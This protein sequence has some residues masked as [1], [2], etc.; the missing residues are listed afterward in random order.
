MLSST[1]LR[2]FAEVA[3]QGSFRAAAEQLH[4]AVSAISRQISLLEEELGSPLFERGRGRRVLHLTAAGEHLLRYV[5]DLESDTRRMRSDI[6]A[7]KGMHKGQIR[8]GIP[9]SFIHHLVPELLARFNQAYPAITYR[10]EVANTPRLLELVAEGELDVVLAYNP[11]ELIDVKHVH[12]IRLPRQVLVPLGHPLAEREWVRLSDCAQYGM[13]LPGLSLTA[14]GI[15]DEMFAKAKIK[16]RAVVVSNSYELL[17]TVSMA[18][19]SICLAN[20]QLLASTDNAERAGYRCV[21]LRDSRVKPTRITIS[22]RQG[23]SLPVPVLTFVDELKKAFVALQ[24][25]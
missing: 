7:L 15:D 3:R 17:H 5:Y 19:L 8:L 9:E 14:K 23:R 22:V 10:V 6:E 12:E 25:S 21:P 16:P 11:P 24:S 13:A 4:V 1:A 20:G 2:Y 18:G